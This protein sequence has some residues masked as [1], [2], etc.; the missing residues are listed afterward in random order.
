M[1]ELLLDSDLLV[2]QTDL[3]LVT[4]CEFAAST[5]AYLCLFLFV[6]LRVVRPFS[7]IEVFIESREE[8]VAFFFLDSIGAALREVESIKILIAVLNTV[9]SVALIAGEHFALL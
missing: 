9:L 4:W 1:F 3:P 7:F 8:I 6:W 5:L 2:I